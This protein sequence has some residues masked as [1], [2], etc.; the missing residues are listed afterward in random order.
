MPDPDICDG[1]FLSPFVG[2]YLLGIPRIANAA[3]F[4]AM[5]SLWA[6]F[7]AIPFIQY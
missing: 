4:E 2:R 7:N 1:I 6:I 5:F 3:S